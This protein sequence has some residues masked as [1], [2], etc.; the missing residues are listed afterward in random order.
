MDSGDHAAGAVRGQISVVASEREERR[1]REGM[2][3]LTH[4]EGL[5]RTFSAGRAA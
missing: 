2:S 5:A 4:P 3:V 1:E